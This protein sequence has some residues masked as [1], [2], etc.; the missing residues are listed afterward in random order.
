M[1]ELFKNDK[2]RQEKLKAIVKDLHE[3]SDIKAVQRL[4]KEDVWART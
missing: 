1:S 4:P 3:G 2:S